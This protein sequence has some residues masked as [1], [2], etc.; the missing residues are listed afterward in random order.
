M[1]SCE[2]STECSVSNT[3][4]QLTDQPDLQLISIMVLPYDVSSVPPTVVHLLLPNNDPH[5]SLLLQSVG[6]ELRPVCSS[7]SPVTWI[8]VYN[9]HFCVPLLFLFNS[10][11]SI[12]RYWIQTCPFLQ[13]VYISK[14]LFYIYTNNS[15]TCNSIF[16][17]VRAV[18]TDRR[19][20]WWKLKK[21]RDRKETRSSLTE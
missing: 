14:L 2:H 3:T 13:F 16:P 10:I 20:V 5:N 15:S 19:I 7:S 18:P 17:T 9:I 12:Y 21:L 1:G 6:Y 8:I 11:F 4:A